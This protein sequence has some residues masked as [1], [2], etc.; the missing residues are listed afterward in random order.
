MEEIRILFCS[1][2]LEKWRNKI[3]Q[4]NL[5]NNESNK[6]FINKTLSEEQGKYFLM[7]ILI[8]KNKIFRN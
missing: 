5:K 1:G 8:F 3:D 7:L 4:N 2:N 6:H